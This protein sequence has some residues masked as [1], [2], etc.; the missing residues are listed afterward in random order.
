MRANWAHEPFFGYAQRWMTEDDTAERQQIEA[1]W[2]DDYA[3]FPQGEAWDPF[4]T[5]M[6]NAHR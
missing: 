1:A 6:W 5:R 4:V 3:A 2:G